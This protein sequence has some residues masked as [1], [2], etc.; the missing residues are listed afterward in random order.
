ML[1]NLTD[2]VQEKSLQIVGVDTSAADVWTL[3][4]DIFAENIGD[5]EIG[6]TVTLPGQS[7]RLLVFEGE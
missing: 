2:E 4:P 6:S 3:E 7:M 1:T 5:V